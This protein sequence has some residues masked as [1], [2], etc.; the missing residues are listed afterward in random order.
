ML[1]HFWKRKKEELLKTEMY[2]F[3]LLPSQQNF[4]WAHSL[5][6]RYHIYHLPCSW[7]WSWDWVGTE[8]LGTILSSHVPHRGCCSPCC[9]P[10]PEAEM[11]KNHSDHADKGLRRVRSSSG[12]AYT[13]EGLMGKRHPPIW[14]LYHETNNILWYLNHCIL[15][16]HFHSNFACTLTNTTF[17][18]CNDAKDITHVNI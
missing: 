2:L 10:L 1:K 15:G 3:P 13:M 11:I 6:A 7:G 12:R 5:S 16:S 18:Y 9:C 4:R 8:V 17:F 14:V